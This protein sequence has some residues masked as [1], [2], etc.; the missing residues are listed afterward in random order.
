MNGNK[1]IFGSVSPDGRRVQFWNDNV[2]TN[3]SLEECNKCIFMAPEKREYWVMPI[4]GGGIIYTSVTYPSRQSAID[5]C[6]KTQSINYVGEPKLI[7]EEE[8]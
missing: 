3:L 1:I 4:R 7:F 5:S 6:G 2:S 8:I